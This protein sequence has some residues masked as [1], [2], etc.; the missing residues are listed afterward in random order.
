MPHTLTPLYQ[1]QNV[2]IV[3]ASSNP[4][5]LGHRLLQNLVDYGFRG[6]IYPVN[7]S[8][9]DILGLQTL[10]SLQDLVRPV[11]LVIICT[12]SQ[13]VLG[14]LEDAASVG[15][16]CAVVLS[17][18]FGET[19]SDGKNTEE[20]IEALCQSSGLRILGPN[21]MGVY[22]VNDNLNATCF[23][24]LPRTPGP[25]SI[26]SQSGAFGGLSFRELALREIGIAKFISVG[27]Q[28]D[29]SFTDLLD[30]LCEDENTKV[31]GL[32]IE[33][34]KEGFPFLGAL[35]R[36]AN[37]RPVVV[38]KAGHD[39]AGIHAASTHTGS[40]VG[41]YAVYRSVLK[42]AG[43]LI[44][45]DS[46]QFFDAL[47]VLALQPPLN[48]YRVAIMSTSAGPS[49]LAS[50]SCVDLGITVPRFPYELQN[51]LRELTS[52]HEAVSNPVAMTCQ[53]D[54]GNYGPAVDLVLGQKKIDGA[55]AIN[56]FIDRPEFAQGFISAAKKY[57]KPV[58]AFAVDAP[59]T[60][61]AFKQAG[62]PIYP[63]PERAVR[64]YRVLLDYTLGLVSKKFQ[65]KITPGKPARTLRQ[66]RQ[67]NPDQFLIPEALVKK[68]LA[69]YGIPVV[70]E[71][72]VKI[73]STT[74]R[75]AQDIGFPIALK[76]HSA[77]FPLHRSEIGGT[78]LGIETE[79]AL[80]NAWH[81]LNREFPTDDLLAQRQVPPGIEI[82]IEAERDPVFGPVITMGL[83]GAFRDI[84]NDVVLGVCP[85]SRAQV[86]RM[87]RSL[88][89]H[90][91]LDSYSNQPAVEENA[92][93]DV[94]LQVSDFML[95]NPDAQKLSI[96]P[97]IGNEKSIVVVDATIE[98]SH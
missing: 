66:F 37:T 44:V 74:L 92:L 17:S 14:I 83:R 70:D 32:F 71:Q 48:G 40:Q 27:N 63:T 64:A 49:M 57:K 69:E 11:D 31:V 4:K 52:T 94:M 58:I 84:F 16:K 38:L 33:A 7:P 96:D 9:N 93:V 45:D 79:D 6:K 82:V 80:R 24:E 62:I 78:V 12:P 68:S 28:L 39:D 88:K 20:S 1:P 91:I 22:N 72:V 75:A 10:K 30:L 26:I 90:K 25:V 67:D 51:Q 85:L 60:A 95:A 76:V 81:T 77:D 3:G 21:C 8:G 73:W 55:I 47:Q 19:G 43:A 13:Y 34:V 2:A 61:T 53:M 59:D 65:R 86:L 35:S 54:P 97:L 56:A 15:C 36:L 46:E 29:I 98:V 50:D 89:G 5:K 18:G 41:R 87:I 23:K 42:E